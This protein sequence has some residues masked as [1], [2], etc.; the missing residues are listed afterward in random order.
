MEK[1]SRA[2]HC[3]QIKAETPSRGLQPLQPHL[4]T[5][6][7]CSLHPTCPTLLQPLSHPWRWYGRG[8][9]ERGQWF[10]QLVSLATSPTSFGTFLKLLLIHKLR[11]L[12]GAC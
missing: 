6:P 3:T 1:V 7:P 10:K 12:K 11:W 5:P 4:P 2:S 8:L 9:K